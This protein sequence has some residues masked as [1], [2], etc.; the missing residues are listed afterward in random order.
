[1]K[2]LIPFYF[3]L[4]ISFITIIDVNLAKKPSKTTKKTTKKPTKKTTTTAKPRYGWRRFNVDY[5]GTMVKRMGLEAVAFFNCIHPN[6][7]TLHYKSIVDGEK[8]GKREKGNKQIK[9]IVKVIRYTGPSTPENPMCHY[10]HVIYNVT[11][12]GIKYVI[13]QKQYD[14]PKR[15]D[16]NKENYETLNSL[17][18][19]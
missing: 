13:R 15:F 11:T 7:P 19:M 4:L 3:I 14:L 9:L 16:C 1:M 12:T 18:K 10:F 8:R 17:Q 5:Q 6:I 2:Y